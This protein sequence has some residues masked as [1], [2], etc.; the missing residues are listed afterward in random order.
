MGKIPVVAFLGPPGS[1]KDT[2][3]EFL[4]NDFGFF[5]IGSGDILRELRS[6]ADKEP[7]NYEAKIVK[8]ILDQGKYAPTLTI[9]SHWYSVLLDLS[10]RAS[11]GAFNSSIG[12]VFSGSPRKLAEAWLLEDFFN[13][14]PDAGAFELRAVFIDVSEKEAFRRLSQRRICVKCS[15]V[16]SGFGS[17]AEVKVCDRCGGELRPRHDDDNESV[18]SRMDEFKKFVLPAAEFF[19]EKGRLI[20]VD[21]EQ[22]VEGVHKEILKAIGLNQ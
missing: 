9:S 3:A 6:K 11:R 4:I 12:I 15:K 1:G 16:F 19:K 20:S 8:K 2:Q 21:G 18:K 22:S 17:G 5:K 10:D 13:T 7:D 14:W